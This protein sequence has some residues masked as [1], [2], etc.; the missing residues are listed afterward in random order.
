MADVAGSLAKVTYKPPF[1]GHPGVFVFTVTMSATTYT[2]AGVLNLS[3]IFAPPGH[4][5]GV[6]KAINFSIGG[7][8]AAY[9]VLW[10]PATTPTFSNLGTLKLFTA[11]GAEAGGS[12]TLVI[13][14]VAIL[15]SSTDVVQ[16]V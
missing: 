10:T 6:V 1:G 2:A 4:T 15:A 13:T 8:T 12:L 5:A 3:T 9:M 16:A 14:G 11:T 7:S